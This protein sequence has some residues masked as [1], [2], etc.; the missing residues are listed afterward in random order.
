MA[1]CDAGEDWI[2]VCPGCGYAANLEKATSV[3]HA[4]ADPPAAGAA[5]RSSPTPGVRTIEDLARFAGGAPAER[6]IKTLVY[7]VDEQPA[8]VLLRGD[9]ELNEL[10]LGEATGGARRRGRRTPRRSARRSARCPGSLGAVGVDGPARVRRRGAARPARDDDRREPGRLPPAPRRRRARPR[11]GALGATC[12]TRARARPARSCGK[13]LEQKKTIEV[14]HIF[15]LGTA[16]LG[17]DGRARADRRA[18]RSAD[19]DGLLRDR[20]RAHHGRRDRGAPRR[21]RHRAGR[22]AIAPFD[23]VVST[24]K[25]SDAGAAARSP[26]GSTRSSRP[27]GF[28][29]L[30]DDRDERP[31]VKFKDADLIGDPVPDRARPARARQG[32]RR[33]RGAR[34]R[35]DLGGP[36]REVAAELRRLVG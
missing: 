8:L 24:V 19:R 26:S 35:E 25:A 21:E 22:S 30:L 5:P 2:V 12:A 31:G 15:K 32:L 14:G 23:V 11:A 3:A 7:V 18:A 4:V 6:Q 20:H 27:P 1:V 13:P 28:E 9:H 33:V 10:K 29:V 17:A 36:A 16:L 34:R